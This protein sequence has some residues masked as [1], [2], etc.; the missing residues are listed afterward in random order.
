MLLNPRRRR[1][2]RKM[3]ALQRKYFGKRRGKRRAKET[4]IVAT[5]NPRRR[6][7]KAKRRTFRRNPRRRAVARRSFRRNPIRHR[8]HFRR[9][10][11]G[12][13]GFLSGSL[14]PAAIGAGGA[15]AV[16]LLVSNA[17]LP[18]TLRQGTVTPA[19]VRVAASLLIGFGVALVGGEGMGA[20]AAA[21][22]MIVTIYNLVRNYMQQNMP[23]VKMNRYLSGRSRM[24]FVRRGVGFNGRRGLG[25]VRRRRLLRLQGVRP[26]GVP[27][28]RGYA[29]NTTKFRVM[30]SAGGNQRMGYTGPAP[31][32]GRYM[33]QPQR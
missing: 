18:Q 3:S 13:G 27:R 5:G 15:I 14:I 32:L 16:D 11:T 28:L 7:H 23:N 31:T 10:P 22:G 19:V 33:S 17:P 1:R 25:A 24:G 2:V 9:N 12:L 29:G 20:N 21:G 8:R 26:I 6:R 4:V 30:R